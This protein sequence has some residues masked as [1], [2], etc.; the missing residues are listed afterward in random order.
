MI[1]SILLAA[2][3]DLSGMWSLGESGKSEKYPIPVPGD[4]HSALFAA[5]KIPDPY[6]AQNEKQVQWVAERGWEVS[7]DFEVTD[8]ILKAK[9]VVLRLENVDLFCDVYLNGKKIGSTDD[10][11]LRYDFDVKAALVKGRNTIRGVFRCTLAELEKLI[12]DEGP[13]Y[14][15]GGGTVPYMTLLRKP[16]CHGGWDWGPAIMTTGFLGTVQILADNE[17]RVDY[18]Y[19]EQK[20]NDDFTHCTL[21]AHAELS[22][23]TVET[24]VFEIDNPPLWW[25]NG[26]GE[27][28]FY[29]FEIHGVKK[30]IG[31]RKLETV[32]EKDKAP[33]GSDGLSLKFRVNGFDV[34]A[35]GANWIPCDALGSRQTPEKYRD[36]LGSAARANFNTIRVWGGGQYEHDAFYEAC[37]ELGLMI[38]HDHPF[39]CGIYSGEE[40]FLAKIKPEM[41]HQLKRLRDHASIAMW[42]GDNECVGSLN[43][44]PESVVKP[45][46]AAEDF[47]KRVSVQ[48]EMTAK[49]D[50]ARVLWPSSPCAGPGSLEVNWKSSARGD[51]HN[52]SIWGGKTP[53]EKYYEAMPRFVSEFG[54]QSYPSPETCEKFVKREAIDMTN[55]D[56]AFHQKSPNGN[57]GILERIS[58]LFPE[59]ETPEEVIYLS[60]VQQSIG[61][62]TAIEFYR[63]L[64]PW[65]MGTIFWQMND[66]WPV[67]SW[68]SIEYGGK[69]KQLQYAAK[70]FYSPLLAVV[71]PKDGD[72]ASRQL[73]LSVLNDT[74]R[75]VEGPVRVRVI[76][77]D[78]K[79]LSDKSYPCTIAPGGAKK[80]ALL[81]RPTTGVMV[82]EFAGSRNEYYPVPPKDLALENAKVTATP[83]EEGGEWKVRLATDYPALFVVPEAEGLRGEFSDASFTLLPNEERTLVYRRREGE[84]ATFAAFKKALKVLH[85]K[86]WPR[87]GDGMSPKCGLNGGVGEL[88]ADEYRLAAD[89]TPVSGTDYAVA[90]D[91]E[92]LKLRF[93]RTLA[94]DAAINADIERMKI[95]VIS[96]PLYC[97]FYH[98]LAGKTRGKW[99]CVSDRRERQADG[100]T[101]WTVETEIRWSDLG[102]QSP[103]KKSGMVMLERLHSVFF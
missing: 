68:S 25:P 73:D 22:N 87:S 48:T 30:R 9:S 33:D 77:A 18:V 36:L 5:G 100:S 11:Y 74:R 56:F 32:Y 94:K 4:V 21:T 95:V 42:C 1:T 47:F 34:F 29:E 62:K 90:G 92:K 40:R 12:N 80:I 60:Q 61:L 84:K 24:K 43:W 15:T 54:I 23:G 41:E 35:K 96:P 2:A 39:A 51:V 14:P 82:L 55:P 66:C 93:V 13:Y 69:W 52:W 28:R 50:P 79:K 53:Y 76:A 59:P 45:N 99:K 58:T 38:W 7:R 86:G 64:R 20:F 89:Y 75:T 71:Y 6:F 27:R 3:V 103:P 98:T 8:E 72:P 102:L 101:S 57:Q 37:D 78:G 31:L 26:I 70:R 91:D 67:A 19:C 10:R 46:H 97:T 85:L 63:A 81:E 88:V 17:P 83:F 65:C 16:A 44:Y 49:Y